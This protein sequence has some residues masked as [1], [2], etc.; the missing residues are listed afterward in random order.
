MQREH[1]MDFCKLCL[2]IDSSNLQVRQLQ[3]LVVAV[4][5]ITLRQH[6]HLVFAGYKTRFAM[7]AGAITAG[8]TLHSWIHSIYAHMRTSTFY[9]TN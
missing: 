3:R 6:M 8:I 5:R 1:L 7:K 9:I 4:S 2:S